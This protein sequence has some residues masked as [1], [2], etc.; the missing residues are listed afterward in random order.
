MARPA[1]DSSVEALQIRSIG[2]L[3]L[4]Q[5]GIGIR[6]FSAAMVGKHHHHDEP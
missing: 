4:L 1:P 2:Q 5:A 3:Y 6:H